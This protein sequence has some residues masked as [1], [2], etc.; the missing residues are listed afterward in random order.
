MY[1]EKIKIGSIGIGNCASALVQSIEYYRDSNQRGL[2]RPNLAGYNILD[3]Q[4]VAAADISE[5][6]VGKNISEAIKAN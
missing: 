5:D 1:M 4:V 6:K 3:I 2:L